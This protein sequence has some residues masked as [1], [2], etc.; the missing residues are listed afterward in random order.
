MVVLLFNTV[1]VAFM[2]HGRR[3]IDQ[4]SLNSSLFVVIIIYLD[5][6]SRGGWRREDTVDVV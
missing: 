4:S 6:S 3:G 5:T 1:T 2:V